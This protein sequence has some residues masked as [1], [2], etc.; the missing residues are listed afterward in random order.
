M[1]YSAVVGQWH[2]G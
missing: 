1:T 2:F